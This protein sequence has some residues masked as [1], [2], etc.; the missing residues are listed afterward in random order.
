VSVRRVRA[1]VVTGTRAE[2]GLLTPVMR[3]IATHE[4]LELQ[5]VVAGGHLVGEEPTER[6]VEAAFE[7]AGRVPMQAQGETGRAAD[8]A[9]LGRGISGCAQVFADLRPD[10]VVV[11]GDRIEA[12]A[13]ASATSV[14]GIAVAHLHGGDRAE[15]VA[16]EAMRRAISALAH[17][18]LP[19]TTQSAERLVRT[20]EEESRVHVVGS[21]AA[22][23]MRGVEPVA[24]DVWQELGSPGVVVLHHPAGLGDA[25][26]ERL[27]RSIA[28][29]VDGERVLW[30]APNLDAD[31]EVVERVRREAGV[32]GNVRLME[33]L[34]HA[35]FKGVLVRL[36]REGGV[37]VGNS[38][39]GLIEAAIAGV[40]VVDVGPRQAG[41]ERCENAV[42]TD[43]NRVADVRRA[44]EAARGLDVHEVE[45][46]YGDGRTGPRVAA[47]LAG[48]EFSDPALLRKRCW[49]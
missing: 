19:A 6:E 40:R 35:V 49:Y 33:H 32:G 27:A 47:V 25:E 18:H 3:A 16:D 41:R 29:A 15:G 28:G 39:A 48:L 2:F 5:V 43:G 22:D 17:V 21:P 46:P 20:G 8:A 42:W 31:R 13:A 1:A 34:P 30:L 37:L 38:S 10:V 14:G 9:A 36:G 12:L 23:G 45:H 4:A 26:E 44:I 11:L 7:V 24:D